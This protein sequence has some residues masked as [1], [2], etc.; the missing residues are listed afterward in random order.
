MFVVPWPTWL[1]IYLRI[2]TYR[3][4]LFLS[5]RLICFLMFLVMPSQSS[6]LVL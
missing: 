6:P 2:S 1:A 3:S 4:W 5:T